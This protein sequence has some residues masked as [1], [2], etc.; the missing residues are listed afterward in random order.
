MQ[1]VPPAAFPI[2]A[3]ISLTIEKPYTIKTAVSKTID[4]LNFKLRLRKPENGTFYSLWPKFEIHQHKGV[5]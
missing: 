1:P 2:Y 3:S 4:L 5:S